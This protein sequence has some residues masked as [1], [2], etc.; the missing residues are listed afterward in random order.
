[1]LEQPAQTNGERIVAT[2]CML[3]GAFIFAYVVGSVCAIATS[4]NADSSEFKQT[5]DDFND[6]MHTNVSAP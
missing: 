5:M 2:V 4:M 3:L 6:V 1:M